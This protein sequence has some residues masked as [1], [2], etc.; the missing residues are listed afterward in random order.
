[1]ILSLQQS[2]QGKK[3]KNKI[4]K[5]QKDFIDASL[6]FNSEDFKTAK[7]IDEE[8]RRNYLRPLLTQMKVYC[9]MTR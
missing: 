5:E 6:I 4:E 7:N 1:M 2:C 8:E 9:L 3:L